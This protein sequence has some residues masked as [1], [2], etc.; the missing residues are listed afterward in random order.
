MHEFKTRDQIVLFRRK[1]DLVQ[2][3]HGA[4]LPSHSEKK[5]AYN[6]RLLSRLCK[7]AGCGCCFV[8]FFYSLFRALYLPA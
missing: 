7:S 5:G 6:S 1:V 8:S 4:T 3:L 2:H